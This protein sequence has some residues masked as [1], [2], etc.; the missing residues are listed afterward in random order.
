MDFGISDNRQCACSEQAAQ[1]VNRRRTV[2]PL[3]MPQV[4]D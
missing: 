4:V 3:K 2:T 1:I